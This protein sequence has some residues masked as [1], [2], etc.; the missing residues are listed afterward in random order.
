MALKELLAIGVGQNIN[1]AIY[2]HSDSCDAYKELL[3]PNIY[4][5]IKKYHPVP[6]TVLQLSLTS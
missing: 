1:M 6:L 4:N 5:I 2:C 3:V